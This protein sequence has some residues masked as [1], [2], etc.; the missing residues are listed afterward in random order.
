MDS[1]RKRGKKW[2]YRIRKMVNGEQKEISKGG[3]RTKAEAKVEADRIEHEMNLG[4]EHFKGEQLFSDYYRSWVK[5]YKT[6]VYSTETD[7]F[8]EHAIKLVD[9]HFE[10]IALKNITREMY[11]GFLNDYAK[12]RSKETVRK[13]HTKIGASLRDAHQNGYLQRNPALRPIIKGAE[14]QKDSLK[15]LHA[16]EAKALVSELLSGLKP[17]YTSRYMLLLQLATGM[18]ISEVMALQ[19][20]DFDFM[21]NR[22]DINKSWDYKFHNDFKETKNKEARNI[23]VDKQ[24]MKIIKE[25]YDYQLS[26][27]VINSKQLLFIGRANKIPSVHAINKTLRRACTRAGVPVIT[28]HALRHTHASLLILEGAD[29]SYVADRLGHRDSSVTVEVYIHVLKELKQK[30]EEKIDDIFN[31]LF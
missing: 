31:A 22:I 1:F 12:G 16:S 19:F 11:Q 28:S 29:V 9:K 14:G 24:T 20:K 15:Y 18:R 8:Y 13:T 17:T 7:K 4:V 23:S 30:N 26:Q 21:N 6:G 3:F 25:L 10:G 2:E 27:K 5:A